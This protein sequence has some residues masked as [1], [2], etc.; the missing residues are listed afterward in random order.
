MKTMYILINNR[1]TYNKD[2]FTLTKIINYLEES[3]GK[4]ST[5]EIR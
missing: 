5:K 1:I 4:K 3:L 2:I